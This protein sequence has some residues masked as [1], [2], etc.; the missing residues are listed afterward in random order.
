MGCYNPRML[1]KEIRT[2]LRRATIIRDTAKT[3]C[4]ATNCLLLLLLTTA[5][6]AQDS[7]VTDQRLLACDAIENSAE[8][9]ACFNE[10]VESLRSPP[11]AKATADV[12]EAQPPAPG[13]EVR[14]ESA[15]EPAARPDAAVVSEAA[16]GAEPG[17][18]NPASVTY[19]AQAPKAQPAP[20][21]PATRVTETRKTTADLTGSAHIERV[22]QNL[23]GRFTVR[24]DNGQVWRETE[25]SR[26]GIPDA[27]ASVKITR[28]LFGSYRMKIDGIPQLA[29]VRQTE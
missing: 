4:M 5:A 16:P 28:S 17:K 24:L 23:D 10:V 25:G 2:E 11:A 12:V 27:G 29:W 14:P 8:R 6:S 3:I 1:Q 26:V 13:P 22:W 15:P 21:K 18:D 9:L 20:V 7:T 19:E